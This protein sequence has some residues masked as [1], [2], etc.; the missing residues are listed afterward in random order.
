[1]VKNNDFFHYRSGD[2][3]RLSTLHQSDH[4]TFLSIYATIWRSHYLDFSLLPMLP[5][6]DI[7]AENAIL[8][9]QKR[10]NITAIQVEKEK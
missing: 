7:G 3:A 5:N 10:I 8:R 4:E 6:D 1:M 2:S 9:R